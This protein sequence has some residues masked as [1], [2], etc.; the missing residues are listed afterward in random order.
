MLNVSEKCSGLPTS[1]RALGLPALVRILQT[2]RTKEMSIYRE[3]YFKELAHLILQVGK[4]KICRVGRRPREELMLQLESKDSLLR[5]FPLSPGRS[6]FFLR[7]SPDWTRP[8]HIVE[9]NLLY[10]VY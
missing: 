2:N 7:P 10:S 3:I 8:T 6:A 4:S 5:G 9:D 1:I